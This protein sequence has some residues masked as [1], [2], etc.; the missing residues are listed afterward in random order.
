MYPFGLEHNKFDNNN[1]K[2]NPTPFQN[3]NLYF[4]QSMFNC[5]LAR[6]VKKN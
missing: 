3:L 5:R 6:S 1:N 2:K 4:R